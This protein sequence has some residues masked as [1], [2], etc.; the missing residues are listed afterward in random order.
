MV[1]VTGE[2][3]RLARSAAARPKTN[4]PAPSGACPAASRPAG[5]VVAQLMI[6]YEFS[7]WRNGVV[8]CGARARGFVP[9]AGLP[10]RPGPRQPAAHHRRRRLRRMPV[11]LSRWI[12]SVFVPEAHRQRGYFKALYQHVKDE[13]RRAGAR[14]LRLYADDSNARAH[15]AVSVCGAGEGGGWVHRA[16]AAWATRVR[17]RASEVGRLPPCLPAAA[18][19]AIGDA[20]ALPRV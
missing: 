12:Q 17:L 7:D 4:A 16:R 11:F 2:R 8:W 14:G 15:A 5:Q 19:R 10:A 13:A 18:V 9:G 6:T 20:D 3:A 1:S